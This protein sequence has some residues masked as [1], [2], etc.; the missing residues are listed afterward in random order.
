MDNFRIFET[1]SFQKDLEQDFGGQQERIKNK[2]L[3][4]VY[5]QLSAQPY[6]GK[7][8]KKLV[9]YKPA[10]WRYRIGNYRFFYE[11]DDRKRIV[12]MTAADIR[13]DAY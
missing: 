10:S 6:F 3:G 9:N 5:P 2:L 12:F 13:G 4:Y 1:E 8:I 7:N 11:I